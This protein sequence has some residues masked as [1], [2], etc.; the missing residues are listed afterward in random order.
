MQMK[1]QTELNQMRTQSHSLMTIPLPIFLV[2]PNVVS[3]SSDVCFNLP[4]LTAIK[5]MQRVWMQYTT[6][7]GPHF[8]SG[9]IVEVSGNMSHYRKTGKGQKAMQRFMKFVNHIM[10]VELDKG[11]SDEESALILMICVQVEH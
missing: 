11:I 8:P 4:Q 10:Q 7:L 3:M 2:A 5:T 6:G 9:R 1:M